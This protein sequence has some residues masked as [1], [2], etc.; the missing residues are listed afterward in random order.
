V[1]F[2]L[3]ATLL[4]LA[5]DIPEIRPSDANQ[6]LLPF[7]FPH[8]F[9]PEPSKHTQRNRRGGGVAA[10]AQPG[11]PPPAAGR[12]QPQATGRQR[13]ENRPAGSLDFSP[14][15]SLT[16]LFSAAFDSSA[17]WP[18]V[19]CWLAA[20]ATACCHGRACPVARSIPEATMGSASPAGARVSR[21]YHS[22]SS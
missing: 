5:N 9:V 11:Q 16:A 12:P 13:R 21:H 1:Q 15:L 19:A 22:I 20:V 17:T 10:R 2:K 4:I 7:A 14:S 3:Q 18:A 8:A 6:T